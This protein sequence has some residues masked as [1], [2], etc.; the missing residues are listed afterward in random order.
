MLLGIREYSSIESYP[1][2][3]G[4]LIQEVVA[5][6]H[7][8]NS[9]FLFRGKENLLKSFTF[10]GRSFPLGKPVD[11]GKDDE[12]LVVEALLLSPL[13]SSLKATDVLP[14]NIVGSLSA[15]FVDHFVYFC[16]HNRLSDSAST[17][18]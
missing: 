15:L 18:W 1:Q 11:P 13:Q 10:H 4:G 16:R 8:E 3:Y 5:F 6:G 9:R 17:H 14:H 7:G 12:R 2:S